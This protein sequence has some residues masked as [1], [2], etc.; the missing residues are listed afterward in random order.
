MFLLNIKIDILVQDWKNSIVEFPQSIQIAIKH[1]LFPELK[2]EGKNICLISHKI[3]KI[4][5][6][7]IETQEQLKIYNWSV[8]PKLSS[9]G[10]KKGVFREITTQITTKNKIHTH[11]LKQHFSQNKSPFF[12]LFSLSAI[13]FKT[14]PKSQLHLTVECFF[15]GTSHGWLDN[16]PKR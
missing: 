3:G 14:F 10:S 11:K 1:Y 15:P 7:N 6:P 4:F 13:F 5:H 16:F 9:N 12:K 8:V 2:I